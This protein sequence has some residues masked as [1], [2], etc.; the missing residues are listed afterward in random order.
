M[1]G[2]ICIQEVYGKQSE[3]FDGNVYVIWTWTV[4]WRRRFISFTLILLAASLT[5][6]NDMGCQDITVIIAVTLFWDSVSPCPHW[7]ELRRLFVH[8]KTNIWGTKRACIWSPQ[9]K[10][11]SEI[12]EMVI[13]VLVSESLKNHS[14]SSAPTTNISFDIGA[15]THA[16][17]LPGWFQPETTLSSFR[18]WSGKCTHHHL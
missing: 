7:R 1:R 17:A 3:R 18:G 5:E 16:F 10:E 9:Q 12:T 6:H 2:R 14:Q 8:E 15:Q 4:P 11:K 13:V